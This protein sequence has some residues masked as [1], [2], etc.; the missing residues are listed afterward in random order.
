MNRNRL[1]RWGLALGV[2]LIPLV[3][4]GAFVYGYA[5]A[6]VRDFVPHYFPL[7]DLYYYR[8]VDTFRAAGFNGGYYATDELIAPAAWSHFDA[9]GPLFPAIYGTLARIF[10][11]QPYK[12]L[13]FNLSFVTAGLIL[14]IVLVRPDARRLLL[15]GALI[16]TS[17]PVLFYIPSGMQESFH[18]AIAMLLAAALAGLVARGPDVP[19]KWIAALLAAIVVVSLIRMTWIFVAFPVIVLAARQRTWKTAIA[20]A[21]GTGALMAVVIAITS[22][23][24]YSPYRT[25]FLSDTTRKT[26]DAL[27]DDGPVEAVQTLADQLARNIEDNIDFFGRGVSLEIAQRVQIV[28][29][30]AIFAAA[31]IWLWRRRR[32]DTTGLT[33]AWLNAYNLGVI[34]LINFVLYL[35]AGWR[36]YRVLAPHLL[37]TGLVLVAL[38]RWRWIALIVVSNLLM[39]IPFKNYYLAY[40]KAYLDADQS[41]I[42]RF[43]DATADVL[44]Y[45]ADEDDAW[46]NTLLIDYHESYSP[47]LIGI[48]GGIGLS[49][50]AVADQLDLPAKSRYVLVDADDYAIL[51]QGTQLE[52]IATTEVGDLYLNLDT[53]CKHTPESGAP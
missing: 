15:M 40:G 26:A 36:D 4:T 24:L 53:S 9:H 47:A 30:T 10:G 11:W 25:N 49:Y 22:G 28:A 14:F 34:L 8:M 23:Y 52:P 12:F 18:Q 1:I 37:L 7:D 19:R 41:G 20:A 39:V 31:A 5:G 29:L 21:L 38:G 50:Y 33:L 35:M 3:V 17:W 46:C 13:L 42:E 16:G 48:P 43:R 27:K 32:G 51:S 2:I 44:V 45:H 6:T